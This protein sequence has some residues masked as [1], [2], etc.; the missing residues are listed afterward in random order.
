MDETYQVYVNRLVELTL[1]SSYPVQLENI[2]KSPK[3]LNGQFVQ[4]PG[5]SVIT[6]PNNEDKENVDFYK[7]LESI[8]SQLL[9][10]LPSDLLIPLPSES[11]HLTLA[12][13]IWD[14]DYKAALAE[15]PQF[16]AQLNNCIGE[17]FF[18]YQQSNSSFLGQW[19]ILGLLVFPRALAVGLVPKTQQDYQQVI[20]LRRAIYQ[21]EDLIDLGLEQR[22]YFAAHI[23]LGYFDQIESELNRLDLANILNSF[24]DEWLDMEPQIFTL[25]EIQ[26][27]Q[28]SDMISYKRQADWPSLEL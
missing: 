8:Q 5:Y 19:Q 25:K 26:L 23:T 9:D 21:N 11:F 1:P 18:R 17:S 28:F 15:N 22:Y 6:P 4:F 14:R 16:E 27:R 2:Q 13:L 7:H 24:N 3:F 12:D 20:E 10:K